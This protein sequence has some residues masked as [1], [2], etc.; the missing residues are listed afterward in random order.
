MNITEIN[1]ELQRISSGEATLSEL[2]DDKFVLVV[3]SAEVCIAFVLGMYY[4]PDLIEG[5]LGHLWANLKKLGIE[6]DSPLSSG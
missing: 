4:R 5:H 6:I 3:K 1:N 2:K